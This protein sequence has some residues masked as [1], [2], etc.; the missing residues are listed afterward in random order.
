MRLPCKIATQVSNCNRPK[1]EVVDKTAVLFCVLP[2]DKCGK[3]LV[4]C[5]GVFHVNPKEDCK[6]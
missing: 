3:K 4:L 1:S 6:S 2:N 5:I